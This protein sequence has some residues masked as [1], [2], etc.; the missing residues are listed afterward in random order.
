MK[1][2]PSQYSN[3]KIYI[4]NALQKLDKAR[5]SDIQK[6]YSKEYDK[7]LNVKT[8]IKYCEQLA[9]ENIVA[10]EVIINNVKNVKESR[11]RP[12]TMNFYHLD[13]LANV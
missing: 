8:L 5:P 11:K 10:R 1:G 12:Y 2:R 7:H 4:I 13:K 9:D 3:F 6:F